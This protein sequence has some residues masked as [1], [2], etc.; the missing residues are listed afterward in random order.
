MSSKSLTYECSLSPNLQGVGPLTSVGGSRGWACCAWTTTTS[1]SSTCKVHPLVAYNIIQH[2]DVVFINDA[3]NCLSLSVYLENFSS[4]KSPPVLALKPIRG[5]GCPRTSVFPT[6]STCTVTPQP[7][8]WFIWV[9]D[10]N[11]ISH[12][13]CS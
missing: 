13:H 11:H 7:L 8:S 1:N 4:T 10:S 3:A 2:D 12:S 9:V 5:R 6:V